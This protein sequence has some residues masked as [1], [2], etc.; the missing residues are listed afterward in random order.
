MMTLLYT[1][2]IAFAHA[3]VAPQGSYGAD[4]S[5]YT[6]APTFA[7][8]FSPT[9]SPTQLPTVPQTKAPTP[10]PGSTIV[11]F[12]VNLVGFSQETFTVC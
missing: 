6:S 2:V 1:C 11:Y 7:P 8:T 9:V 12:D 4:Y 3:D 10:A 5:S